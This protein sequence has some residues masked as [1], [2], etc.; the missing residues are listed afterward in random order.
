[1]VTFNRDYRDYKVVSVYDETDQD[2]QEADE[3]AAFDSSQYIRD[4]AFWSGLSLA[5]GIFIGMAI[6]SGWKGLP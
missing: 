5:I 1:M 3:S 6:V 4:L 2:D